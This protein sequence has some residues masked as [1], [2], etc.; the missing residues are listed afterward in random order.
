MDIIYLSIPFDKKDELKPLKIKW[1]AGQKSWFFQGGELPQELEKYKSIYVDIPYDD[2]E[3]FKSKFPSMS[4]DKERKSWKMSME[5]YA[6]KSKFSTS[7]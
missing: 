6:K 3:I 2:K 5:D 4:F 7:I 1:N